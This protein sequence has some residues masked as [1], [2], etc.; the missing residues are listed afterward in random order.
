MAFIFNP[1]LFEGTGGAAGAAAG[2]A[3]AA[4]AQNSGANS[5]SAKSGDQGKPAVLYGKQPASA[6]NQADSDINVPDAGGAESKAST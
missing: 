6:P 1:H 2:G 5:P 3:Q 4:A